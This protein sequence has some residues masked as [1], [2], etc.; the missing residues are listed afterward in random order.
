[1]ALP[2]IN[3]PTYELEVPSTGETIKYRPFLVKEEKILLIAS[4]SGKQT[5]IIN[6]IKEIATACTFGKLKIGRMPMFDVEYIFLNI[7]AKSVGEVSELPLIA[8]DDNETRV[9]VEVDLSEVKVQETEGHTNKIELTDEM[10]I[11]MQYPT[12]DTF[13]KS[14]MT[15]ITASNM[16]EVISACIGQI[17]DKKGEEVW[18]AQDSTKKELIEFIE[19]LSSKQFGNIQDF[20]DTMPKLK[21][22]LTVKNPKTKVERDVVL[23]GLSDFFV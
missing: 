2:T 13:G 1:M 7:R 21:H 3:T 22:T 14:G 19:Q 9:V 8:P 20:F 6:A 4:E 23:S 12:V 15:E 18:E 10:G 16:L 5:D 11:Y 17:Y